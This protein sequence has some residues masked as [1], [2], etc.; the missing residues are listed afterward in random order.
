MRVRALYFGGLRAQLGLA[1]ELMELPE[2]SRAQDAGARATQGL[3]P[4]WLPVL[5]YGLNDELV[6]AD[7]PLREGDELALLPPVSGG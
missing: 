4:E 6:A 5:R 3:G 1:G 7:A 2:G